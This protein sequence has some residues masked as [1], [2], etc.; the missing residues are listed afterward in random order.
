[1]A[2]HVAISPPGSQSPLHAEAQGSSALP[3]SPPLH[4]GAGSPAVED[5]RCNSGVGKRGRGDRWWAGSLLSILLMA[6][7]RAAAGF[8]MVGDQ[9]PAV[10]DTEEKRQGL[11]TTIQEAFEDYEINPEMITGFKSLGAFDK[12]IH[13]AGYDD[14]KRITFRRVQEAVVAMGVAATFDKWDGI[15]DSIQ[16]RKLNWKELRMGLRLM[17]SSVIFLTL[18][19][20]RS[21]ICVWQK[22]FTLAA[23]AAHT[24]Y[25]GRLKQQSF[26]PACVSQFEA[27]DECARGGEARTHRPVLRVVCTVNGHE[28]K[29]Y[30]RPRQSCLKKMADLMP[31]TRP[32]V[33]EYFPGKK[34][35][36][37]VGGCRE[38]VV[39][40]FFVVSEG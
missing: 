13:C 4:G 31:K 2:Q 3:G 28:F 22:S 29:A 40:I 7:L 35:I 20:I 36:F 37:F 12:G 30:C 38:A 17:V 23:Y 6:C 32:C 33:E 8:R 1:M 19:R 39:W 5:T 15:D 9:W 18:T 26:A 25:C 11:P 10:R 24:Q 21:C 27:T 34:R 16:D 14:L